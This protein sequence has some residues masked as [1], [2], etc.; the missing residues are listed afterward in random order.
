M[1]AICGYFLCVLALTPALS[2]AVFFGV[3]GKSTR[4]HDLLELVRFAVQMAAGVTS[5]FKLGLML[6][7]LLGVFIA[8]APRPA[9]G[10][11][12]FAVGAAG[13]MSVM[14]FVLI[15][16]PTGIGASVFL[17][18]CTAATF[19]SL[20]GAWRLIATTVAMC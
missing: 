17:F 11:V 4:Q 6:A 13:L 19:V 20:S 14:Q 12:L 3:L 15:A 16:S 7:I 18:P 2:L 5:P 9:R 10:A 1:S 8:G